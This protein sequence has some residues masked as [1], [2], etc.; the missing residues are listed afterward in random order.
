M[1]VAALP[2]NRV[3]VME[4]QE[5]REEYQAVVAVSGGQVLPLV[6]V[7]LVLVGRYG[8]GI[9][10]GDEMPSNGAAAGRGKKI[11]GRGNF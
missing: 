9:G 7:E 4:A 3:E 6:L 11:Y 2:I 1:A 8:Y 5:V 10:K